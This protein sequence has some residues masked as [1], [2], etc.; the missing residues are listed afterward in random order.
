MP[1]ELDRRAAMMPQ[2]TQTAIP[3]T[4]H[5]LHHDE[6][7]RVAELIERFVANPADPACLNER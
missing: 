6:P 3:N 4:G 2:V 5:N 7:A 1:G